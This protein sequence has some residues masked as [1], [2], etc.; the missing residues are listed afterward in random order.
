L[1]GW[2][3]RNNDTGPDGS[4]FN[5]AN[6]TFSGINANDGQTENSSAPNPFPIGTFSFSA[7]PEPTSFAA[8]TVLSLVGLAAR[9]RR[10]S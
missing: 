9:R 10:Q 1:D 8:L 5:I 4:T 2:A 6:W 3:Y 7:V